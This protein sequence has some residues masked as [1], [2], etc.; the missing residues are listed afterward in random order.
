MKSIFKMI[1]DLK[2]IQK[3]FEC[4]LENLMRMEHFEIY[5]LKA[6]KN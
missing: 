5:I 1:Y 6:I 3:K 2:L 4:L